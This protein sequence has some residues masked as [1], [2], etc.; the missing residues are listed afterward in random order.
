M[1]HEQDS[2]AFVIDTAE[3]PGRALQRAIGVVYR[4]D[5]APLAVLP[6]PHRRP[7]RRRRPHRRDAGRRAAGAHERVGD[8][9]AAR[10]VSVGGVGR[11]G[12]VGCRRV[13]FA[14]GIE[15][16]VTGLGER[17]APAPR[18]GRTLPASR[19]V[20]R[21]GRGGTTRPALARWRVSIPHAEYLAKRRLLATTARL[22]PPQCRRIASPRQDEDAASSRPSFRT[23]S[24][25]VHCFAQA[26]GHLSRP[27]RR[28][29]AQ[30]S[31]STCP[32]AQDAT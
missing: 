22:P 19:G 16:R 1:L 3:L 32:I 26:L 7:V 8:R 28:R 13:S 14:D 18:H 12:V 4:P 9:R 15:G 20:R 25:T 5:R 31:H 11:R 2:P 27:P 6:C 30:L 29:C 23:F 21:I 17:K 24:D 10:D